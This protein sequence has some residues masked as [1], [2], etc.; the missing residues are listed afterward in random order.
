MPR[1]ELRVKRDGQRIHKINTT[2]H[3]DYLMAVSPEDGEQVAP[4]GWIGLANQETVFAD[5]IRL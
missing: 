5:T 1:S 4:K 2:R 3:R